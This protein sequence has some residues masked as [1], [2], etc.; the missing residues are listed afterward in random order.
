LWLGNLRANGHPN[1]GLWRQFQCTSYQG[2]VSEHH[3]TIFHD[4]QVAVELIVRVL[5]YLAEGV[6]IRATARVFE[7]DPNTVLHW[8]VEAAEH[9][10][11]FS[12]DFLC[13]VHV[14]GIHLR[15]DSAYSQLLC[16]T[17]RLR[18]R[19]RGKADM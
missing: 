12:C 5:A 1:G 14:K 18:C 16:S 3:G 11:A 8:M 9:L 19:G 15:Q 2:Y 7:V 17:S 6:G 13:D 10:R 4:K